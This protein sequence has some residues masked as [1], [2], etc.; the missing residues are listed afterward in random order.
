MDIVRLRT[1]P[2]NTKARG[3]S[4]IVNRNPAAALSPVV[5]N[6][7]RHVRNGF[8][9]HLSEANRVLLVSMGLA[10]HA[11][12]G[13]LTITELG[14]QRLILENTSALPMAERPRDLP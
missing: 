6:A 8:T 14:R 4:S 2:Y 3:Y 11:P 5:L 13:R 7:L 9:T 12:G 1:G 10:A